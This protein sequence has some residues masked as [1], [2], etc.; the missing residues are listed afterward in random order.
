MLK[1]IREFR[2]LSGAIQALSNSLNVL[3][4]EREGGSDVHSRLDG[5]E[6]S[7]LKWEAEMEA[8]ILQAKGK[9]QAANNAEMRTRSMAKHYESE[10]DDFD[11]DG[12]EAEEAQPELDLSGS[13][14]QTSE[15]G[16]LYGLPVGMEANGKAIAT[17]MKFGG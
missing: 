15:A 7:K 2:S 16:G 9:Y 13:D 10:L 8:L 6:I 14:V 12:D 3:A 4:Q 5:L 1:I 17:R 11:S